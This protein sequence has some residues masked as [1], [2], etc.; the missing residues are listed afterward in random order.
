MTFRLKAGVTALALILVP[1]ALQAAPKGEH[2]NS[3]NHGQSARTEHG[4]GHAYGHDRTRGGGNEDD[5]G[6]IEDGENAG[7][8][9]ATTKEHPCGWGLANRDTPCVPPGQAARGVTTEQW[10]GAPTGS[11]EE[12]QAVADEGYGIITNTDQLGLD[13][14]TLP[15]GQSYA[16]VG[17]T[18]VVVDEDGTVISIVRRAAIPGRSNG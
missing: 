2:G 9:V 6:E 15:E 14:S 8:E 18:I 13:T 4:N 3:G 10:I 16:L 11:V 5:G 1:L 7:E 12:L 17:D